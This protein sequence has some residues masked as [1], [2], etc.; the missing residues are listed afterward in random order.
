MPEKLLLGKN[1]KLNGWL[2][3]ILTYTFL[4]FVRDKKV[5]LLVQNQTALIAVCCLIARE[6]I[7]TVL[8]NKK[9]L[10]KLLLVLSSLILLIP[11]LSM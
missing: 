7:F 2:A 10:A 4:Q 11:K 3:S 1:I 6:K 8:K 9:M 5:Q